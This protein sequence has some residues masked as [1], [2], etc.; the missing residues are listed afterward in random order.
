MGL[1]KRRTDRP[2]WIALFVVAN[3]RVED[4]PDGAVALGGDQTV[5]EPWEIDE[6]QLSG[7]TYEYGVVT[8][9]PSL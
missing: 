8:V 1:P 7:L 3:L 5:I 6:A 2:L 9:R 4:G